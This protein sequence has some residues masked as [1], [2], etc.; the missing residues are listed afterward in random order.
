MRFVTNAC[1]EKCAVCMDGDKPF[2]MQVNLQTSVSMH[3]YPFPC[4]STCK[5][6]DQSLFFLFKKQKQ[7]NQSRLNVYLHCVGPTDQQDLPA[8]LKDLL[9]GRQ[10]PEF[11]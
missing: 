5:Y 8:H 2:D 11:V 4:K 6:A 9:D 10:L 3:T 7:K 1:T